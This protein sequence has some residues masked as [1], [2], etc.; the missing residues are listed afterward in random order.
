[1]K[2]KNRAVYRLEPTGI[3]DRCDARIMSYA[4]AE[5]Q[6]T[7]PFGCP[8]NGTMRMAYVQTLDGEFIGLVSLSSLVKT[9]RTAPLRDLA[10]E[11]RDARS[12]AMRAPSPFQVV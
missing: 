4:D 10:A 12:A 9:G 5:V 8:P 2:T 6:K 1:M 7:Q 3:L 11:A